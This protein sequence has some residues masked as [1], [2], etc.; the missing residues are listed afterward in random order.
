MTP[1]LRAG[2]ALPPLAP[3]SVLLLRGT[4]DPGPEVSGLLDRAL[5]PEEWARAEGL[6]IP[7]VNR[8]FRATRGWMRIVLARFMGQAP[9]ALVFTRGPAGK[10]GLVDGPAFN[11]SHTGDHL[12]LALAIEGALGVDAEESRRLRDLEGLA[13][14]VFTLQEREELLEF[15]EGPMR[16]AAFLRGWTRKEA[17]VKAMGRGI[18]LPL[19]QVSVDLLR[20]EG[21]LLRWTHPSLAAGTE[22]APAGWTIV[23]AGHAAPQAGAAA[24]AWNR[25]IASIEV[26]DLPRG[27]AAE[28]WIRSGRS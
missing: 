17:L 12:L 14:R 1:S 6:R 20:T 11:M 15:P 26:M 2:S 7:S 22:G 10:P 13:N 9:E 3:G 23:D 28:V 4:L 27:P 21:C 19:Q 18:S 8:R 5:T 16:E 24:V 25:P